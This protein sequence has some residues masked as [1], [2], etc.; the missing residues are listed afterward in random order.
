ME[1]K[2]NRKKVQSLDTTI[3]NI[4]KSKHYGKVDDCF[5]HLLCSGGKKV[6]RKKS[7]TE[8]KSNGKKVKRKKSPTEKKSNGKK[9][10]RKKSPTKKVQL[11][12]PPTRT[13]TSPQPPPPLPPLPPPPQPPPPPIAP[14]KSCK[15]R[16]YELKMIVGLFF[17]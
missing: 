17:R 3:F 1:K 10:Q 4:Y 9:V 11:L 16:T 7:P 5:N 6:Q 8:K 15:P 2:S 12:S 13:P 14:P